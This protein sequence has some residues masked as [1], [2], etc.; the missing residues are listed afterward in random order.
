M[1]QRYVENVLT[2]HGVEVQGRY[3]ATLIHTRSCLSTSL[4]FDHTVHAYVC[5]VH[6]YI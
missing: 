5:T 2:P 6:N 1:A 3:L 4:R